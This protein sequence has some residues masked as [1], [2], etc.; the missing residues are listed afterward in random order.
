MTEKEKESKELEPEAEAKPEPEAGLTFQTFVNSQSVIGFIFFLIVADYLYFGIFPSILSYNSFEIFLLVVAAIIAL[1]AASW[2]GYLAY[3]QP[4]EERKENK[5]GLPKLEWV[6]ENQAKFLAGSI[7]VSLIVTISVVVLLAVFVTNRFV[8]G[9]EGISTD[10][11]VFS[12]A[13]VVASVTFAVTIWRGYQTY[14][15]IRKT[16]EQVDEAQKQFN[17]ARFENALQMAT[18]REN[19]GRCISG[20]RVLE[21]MYEDLIFEDDKETV[22]S[23]A[24]YVLSL[25][26]EGEKRISSSARQRALDIL[27][28]KRFL[29]QKKLKE[30]NK[31]KGGGRELPVRDSMVDKDLSRLT[32]TRR[33]PASDNA[34]RRI[35]DL[36]GFSFRGC[37]FHGANLSDVNFSNCNL[38]NTI[39]FGTNLSRTLLVDV[40]GFP[41]NHTFLTYCDEQPRIEANGSSVLP[42]FY[43]IASWEEWKESVKRSAKKV[44]KFDDDLAQGSITKDSYRPAEIGFRGEMGQEAWDYLTNLAKEDAPYPPGVVEPNE[45]EEDDDDDILL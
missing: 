26:K 30:S 28:N 13:L 16:R 45:E 8:G 42:K 25:P 24:L 39:F 41:L 38:K 3:K 11:P 18:E 9:E 19:A 20:L 36:S 5:G 44:R 43:T 15:Q 21:D 40:K 35:L 6:L 22:H 29:S 31:E 27:V 2:K 14:E 17:Q 37:D 4:L 33:S 1:I 10:V 23:V 7:V 34:G 32:L 12:L